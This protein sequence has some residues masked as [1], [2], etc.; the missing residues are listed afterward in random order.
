MSHGTKKKNNTALPVAN[1]EQDFA[2]APVRSKAH[3]R[4]DTP[5]CLLVHSY[6][7]RLIDVDGISA[8][9]VIDGLV[10]AEVF[11]DDTT[12]SIQEVRFK[13]TKIGTKEAEKTVIEIWGE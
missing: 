3:E 7:H 1:M 8:K 11:A 5:L 6:R 4:L 9:A 2:N 12:K 10:H 13:Q